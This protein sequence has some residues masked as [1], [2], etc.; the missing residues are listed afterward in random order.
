MILHPE[1]T[2]TAVVALVALLC[3]AVL[4]RM[5]Q[6]PLI[7]YILAGALLG[8]FGVGFVGS[9]DTVKTLA[10]FGILL[11]LFLVGLELD[12]RRFVSV[13]RVSL[14]AT[15]IQIG[16]SVGMT[17]LLGGLFGWPLG[18][19]VLLGFVIATSSTAVVIKTLEDS[20]EAQ[21]PAGR[22]TLGITI[23]QDIAVVPMML[24][25]AG[26]A[27]ESIG[28]L[29]MGKVAL[30]LVLLAGLIVVLLRFRVRLP[31]TRSVTG[32]NELSPI[33]GLAWCFGAAALS[34]FLGLSAAYGA[35][36]A[37]MV[38]GNSA[39]RDSQLVQN[40]R[41]IQSV[42]M[43]V[44][45]LSIGMMLDLSFILK[46]LDMVLLLLLLVTVFKT[47]LNVGA[48][49][50]LGQSWPHAAMAGVAVA[51]IGEFSFL[52]SEVGLAHGLITADDARLVVS[53]AVLSLMLSPVWTMAAKSLHHTA[54]GGTTPGEDKRASSMELRAQREERVAES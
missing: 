37:G 36:L 38:L 25:L 44:F 48:L 53:V 15:L 14:L 33:L 26:L 13:W 4:A 54:R 3:G 40:I 28:I 27:S 42:L 35:F 11:L 45:F 9:Q 10:E 41:P 8:P 24:V 21:S 1:I 29:D 16:G 30:S 43:M 17:L 6:S 22:T 31:F 39:A 23:A 49:R 19:A 52:L 50:L 18:L 5:R 20:G 47:V 32:H 34:G 12:L 2:M 7:G 46:H 51:Q